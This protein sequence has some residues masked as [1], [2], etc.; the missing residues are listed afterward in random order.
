MKKQSLLIVLIIV[1]SVLSSTAKAFAY[2]EV[3]QTILL[4]AQPAVSV[5]KVSAKESCTIKAQD[6]THEGLNAS[7]LLQTN[8][9]DEDYDF[10]VGSNLAVGESLYSGFTKNGNLIFVNMNTTPTSDAIYDAIQEGNQNPNVI[11]YPFSVSATAPMTTSWG[12]HSTHGDCYLIKV[13]EQSEGTITKS[14]GGT[15]IPGT[16][17]LGND[18]AGPYQAIVYI[19]VVQK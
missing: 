18:L 13:N 12:T 4:S 15:P 3:G 9:T 8:G 17:R 1:T 6:G 7:F 16:Y 14:V 10:I 11:V 5:K 19:T 2:T